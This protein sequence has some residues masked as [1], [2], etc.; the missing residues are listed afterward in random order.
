MAVQFYTFNEAFAEMT[1]VLA[2]GLVIGFAVAGRAARRKV[3]RLAGL[4]A[5][6][7]AGARRAGGAVP[8][9]LAAALPGRADQAGV[10]F[11]AAVRCG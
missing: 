5:I 4:T 11:L 2:G 9:L 3:A 1:A 10:R 6:A 7:Y 8:D